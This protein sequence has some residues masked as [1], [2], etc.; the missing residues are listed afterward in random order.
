MLEDVGHTGRI[1]GR[2]GEHH[3]KCVVVVGG[4]NVDVPGSGAQ[5]NQFVIGPVQMC[6]GL[7]ALNPIAADLRSGEQ[8]GGGQV[9]QDKAPFFF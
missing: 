7:P 2:S 8:L 3:H 5:V 6:D 9:S 1:A 4:F